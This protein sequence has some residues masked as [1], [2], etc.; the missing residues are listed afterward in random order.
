M[1]FIAQRRW[2][3]VAVA[4]VVVIAAIVIAEALP[5]GPLLAVVVGAATF[6][7]GLGLLAAARMLAAIRELFKSVSELRTENAT[8]KSEYADKHGQFEQVRVRLALAE[9]RLAA[10]AIKL[11]A[12]DGLDQTGA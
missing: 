5:L 4:F 12:T 6:V 2:W 1:N 10:L 3:L 11:D 8:L 9:R 7:G